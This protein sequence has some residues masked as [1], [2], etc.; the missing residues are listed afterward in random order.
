[1]HRELKSAVFAVLLIVAS[2]YF[3][4]VCERIGQGYG[5]ILSPSGETLDLAL[6]L[7]LA[8]GAVA[9][10]AGLVAALVRPRWACFLIF[11]LSALAMLLGWELK[12]SGGVLT[13]AYFIASLIYVERIAG[14]LNDRLHFSVRPISQSQRIL[15][16]TL[17]IVACGS[18]YFGYAAEIEREGFSIPPALVEMVVER[19]EKEVVKFLPADLGEVALTSIRDQ[20]ERVLLDE[21]EEDVSKRL[22]AAPAE[23]VMAEFGRRFEKILDEMERE[24]GERLQAVEREAI[25]ARFREQFE[26]TLVEFVEEAIRPYERWIPLVFA[27]S[28]FSLLATITVLLSWIPVV[29]LMVIFPLLTALG[30]TKVVAETGLIRRLT[31]G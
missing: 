16:S 10:T 14:E 2:Y 5:L 26:R 12:A 9:I 21:M 29:A 4:S 15:I 24:A 31:L 22:P 1:M 17:I 13:V 11:A 30:V 3:G 6:R 19:M 28:L 7:L 20:F 23:V 18:F 27:I 25:I 8:M